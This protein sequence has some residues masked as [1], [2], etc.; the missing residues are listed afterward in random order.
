MLEIQ[1]LDKIQSIFKTQDVFTS[2]KVYAVLLENP[3]L[4]FDERPIFFLKITE[5]SKITRTLFDTFV[6]FPQTPSKKRRAQHINRESIQHIIEF[7]GKYSF[8]QKM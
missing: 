4:S 5:F 1:I 6:L 2:R 7:I 3:N 8:T